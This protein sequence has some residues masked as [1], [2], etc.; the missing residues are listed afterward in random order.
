M[1]AQ[2]CNAVV[3][4]ACAAEDGLVVELLKTHTEGWSYCGIRSLGMLG[5]ARSRK[6]GND[7]TSLNTSWRA[8][9]R[10]L[11]EPAKPTPQ[12]PHQYSTPGAS[13]T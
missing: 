5:A 11:A 8:Q 3:W 1:P 13:H 2:R 6:Q 10:V 4:S 12:P 9:W 7:K